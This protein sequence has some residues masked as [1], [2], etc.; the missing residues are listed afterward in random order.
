MIRL[1]LAVFIAGLAACGAEGPPEPVTP[2]ITSGGGDVDI[3]VRGAAS[4]GV[5]GSF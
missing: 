5:A 3:A 4:I 2:G 1:G